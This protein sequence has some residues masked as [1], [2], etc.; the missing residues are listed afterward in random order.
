MAAWYGA[1]IATLVLG[2]DI[3]KWKQRGV[4]LRLTVHPSIRPTGGEP[5]SNADKLYI[6]VEVVNAGDKRTELTH[7]VGLFYKTRFRRISRGKFQHIYVKYPAFTSPPLPAY[8]EAGESWRGGIEQTEELEEMSRSGLL[9]CGVLYSASKRPLVHR[10][11]IK[12]KT[13]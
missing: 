11:V 8:L 3:F 5:N 12:A 9:Y 4:R 10:I 1:A 2:W 13:I 7:L 6:L